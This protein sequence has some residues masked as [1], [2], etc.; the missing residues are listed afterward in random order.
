MIPF[1]TT[2]ANSSSI[3]SSDLTWLLSQTPP[4]DEPEAGVPAWPAPTTG[5][6][7]PAAVAL[8]AA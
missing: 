7:A 1:E 3:V 8:V 4:D 5:P 2:T 6:L